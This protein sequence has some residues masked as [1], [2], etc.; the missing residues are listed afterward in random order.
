MVWTLR[1]LI[2][3]YLGIVRWQF[4]IVLPNT[5][6]ILN[7][8][9]RFRSHYQTHLFP[10][11][12][13]LPFPMI[14]SEIIILVKTNEIYF[15]P[16]FWPSSEEPTYPCR[17]PKTCRFDICV[18]ETPWKRAWQPTQ[19][20]WPRESHGWR[21]LVGYGPWDRKESDVTGW[22]TLS[23]SFTMIL[24]PT[25]TLIVLGLDIP[26]TDFQSSHWSFSRWLLVDWPDC[27]SVAVLPLLPQT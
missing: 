24:I 20:F 25:F 4:H 6:S 16:W 12:S 21:N 22:L 8:N 27:R 17:R 18:W 14:I 2:F 11:L 26:S 3:K 5:F 10:P 1:L 15:I 9:L 19:V 13:I 7:K 23:L